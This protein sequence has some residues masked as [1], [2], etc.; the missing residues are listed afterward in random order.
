MSDQSSDQLSS[1]PASAHDNSVG[2]RPAS[3]ALWK[4][5]GP[6]YWRN[7]Q[8][9]DGQ[10]DAP[11]AGAHDHG[12]DDDDHHQHHRSGSPEFPEG[13]DV[14]EGVS[15][16]DFV[17]LLGATLAVSGTA[18]Y[19]PKQKIVPYVRRPPEVTPGNPLHFT[20]AY[21][22]EGYGIGLLIE[23][24]A[25]RPTKVEGNPDHP[26]SLGSTGLYEQAL[27]L[28]LYDDDRAKSLR[29]R[30]AGLAWR[31]LLPVLAQHGQRLQADGGAKLRFLVEPSR[32]PLLADLRGRV[33][34][35]FPRAKMVSFSSVAADGAAEGAQ[36]AFG[37]P[38]EPRHNLAAARVILS[39]DSDFLGDGPEQVRL[40]RQFGAAREPGPN[41]NRLYVAEPC[42][43]VT[44]E[45]ADHR[46]R[47]RG[48]DILALAQTLVQRLGAEAGGEALSRLGALPAGTATID[49]RWVSAA[50]KDLLANR[51]RSLVIAG[52]RQPAAVHA[53]VDAINVALGN[54]G[55]TVSF[56]AAGTPDGRSGIEPLRGLVEEIAAGQVDTLVIT[57]NNP[58]YGAP[59]DFKLE[60]LL[61]RVPH[62]IYMG[63]HED[64]T[65][66]LAETFIPKAHAFESWGDSEALD[67]TVSLVQPLIY[68]LWGGR[69]EAELLAGFVG[70]GDKG[71]HALLKQLWQ[72]RAVAEGRATTEA[73]EGAWETWLATGLLE[74]TGGQ[75]ETAPAVEGAGL[76]ERLGPVIQALPK[77]GGLEVGFQIDPKVFDGRFANNAW[78]Q[79]LPHPIS[80]LTWDN[81]VL[82]SA[83]TAAEQQIKD[84]DVVEVSVGDRKI[85][86]P[87]LIQPGH[88]DNAVTLPLGYG[89]MLGKVAKG[90]GFNAGV[91]RVSRAPWFELGGALRKTGRRHR[92]GI[93][94]IHW[95]MEGRAPVQETKLA[96]LDSKKFH[97]E[98][99]TERGPLWT[100]H[101]PVDYSK[102][103]Y[104][105]AMSID[106]NQCTGCSV[107]VMACV[108]ENNI[109]VV[110]RENVRV[111]REMQW[112]RVDRYYR[113]EEGAETTSVPQPVACVHCETAPCEYVCPVNATTHSDEGL[114]EMVY[115]RCVGTRYCSN[116]C[117]YKARRFNFMDYHQAPSPTEKMAA[118]P[119]VTVRSRG[120]MEKCTYCV[121]RIER[122]R[123]DARIEGRVIRDGEILTACQQAC[124]TGA[125]E[126]GSLN[127]PNARVT[128]KHEDHRRYDLLHELNTRPR[129][130]Y[131]AR[132]RNPNPELG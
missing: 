59:S 74:K 16:R 84:G 38:L 95:K 13:A 66:A 89:R 126:F 77:G 93:T 117:P 83:A 131:L 68:P 129:T 23:S 103:P 53:L 109:P 82:L 52:R 128:K 45:M 11:S 96:E 123:I 90:V 118:N 113:E 119:D 24:H 31:G 106:L 99:Q 3:L 78:L 114:N 75:P 125:I 22:L 61:A 36:L 50:A 6:R 97:H 101:K 111:G 5:S 32:S 60:R 49:G 71:A 37:R 76:A 63:S 46:M 21:A 29:H 94:Q 80:K 8:E 30:G 26:D 69:T 62:V 4:P 10:A 40:S 122:S 98:L 2:L 12:H 34:Q 35:K 70:E 85:E 120:I 65:A 20:S 88:A 102:Q 48:S 17:S 105:W 104:K 115:N 64:E 19:R 73:F 1:P 51:G 132:V 47:I 72:R 92:F 124:P 79:E 57:A 91:V 121:Q 107:C 108:S 55:S 43:T 58:V 7:L 25:G 110:G 44:G 81:A 130:A 14:L 86:G 39:L 127:D 33:V 87:A 41:M 116:N 67:G 112:I 18:C 100:I 42:P 54:V 9:R 15:R 56:W 27:T 28:D